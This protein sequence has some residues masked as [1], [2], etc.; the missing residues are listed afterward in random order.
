MLG[1]LIYAGRIIE[2]KMLPMPKTKMYI[3]IGSHFAINPYILY[4]IAV[5]VSYI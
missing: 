4:V 2:K 3:H 5:I 1:Y